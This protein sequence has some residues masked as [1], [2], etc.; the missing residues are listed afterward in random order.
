MD[1][2]EKFVATASMILLGIVLFF[3]FLG[4]VFNTQESKCEDMCIHDTMN[5]PCQSYDIDCGLIVE[6]SRNECV[7]GCMAISEGDTD[8]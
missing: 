5:Q 8:G 4:G 1:E 6:K 2:D 3:C 7:L